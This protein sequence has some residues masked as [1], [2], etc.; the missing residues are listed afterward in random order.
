MSPA[1][2]LPDLALPRT[3]EEITAAAAALGLTIPD[4]CLP[5]VIANLVLLA[6]HA[7]RLLADDKSPCA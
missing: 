6:S 5:G 2:S 4:A 1:P 7:D 3:A